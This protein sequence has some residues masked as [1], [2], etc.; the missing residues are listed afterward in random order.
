MTFPKS[1]MPY[2]VRVFVAL[3]QRSLCC[4]PLLCSTLV[5]RVAPSARVA[6]RASTASR[7]RRPTPRT[8]PRTCDPSVVPRCPSPFSIPR[9]TPFTPHTPGIVLLANVAFALSVWDALAI[10]VFSHASTEEINK[11]SLLS[12]HPTP[13]RMR[14]CPAGTRVAWKGAARAS[15][16]PIHGG[17]WVHNIFGTPK[18]H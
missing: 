5:H 9:A 14:R 18:G 4:A 12:G 1:R 10:R 15:P 8:Q 11:S 2:C 3:L 6:S 17:Y 13:P 16:H 7:A